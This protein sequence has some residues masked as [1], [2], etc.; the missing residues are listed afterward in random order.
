M[1]FF[2]KDV[3]STETQCS[4]EIYLETDLDSLSTYVVLDCVA[5]RSK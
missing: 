1:A 5:L 2:V 3:I 4:G